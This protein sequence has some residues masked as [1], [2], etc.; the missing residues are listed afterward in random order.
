MRG[1]ERRMEET[2]VKMMEGRGKVG[3]RGGIDERLRGEGR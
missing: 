1:N 2:V 3:D